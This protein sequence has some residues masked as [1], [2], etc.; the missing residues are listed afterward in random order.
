MITLTIQDLKTKK[1]E[2]K[3]F[4]SKDAAEKTLAT[5]E[6]DPKVKKT[7]KKG[8]YLEAWSYDTKSEKEL[9]ESFVIESRR[10]RGKL[11]G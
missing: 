7:L 6:T 11:N 5:L 9:I 3:V 8:K 1:N 10:V 2:I 4:S